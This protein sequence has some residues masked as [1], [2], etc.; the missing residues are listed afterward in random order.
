MN[1]ILVSVRMVSEK[2]RKSPL[3][4]LGKLLESMKSGERIQEG[5]PLPPALRDGEGFAWL[6]R[7]TKLDLESRKNLKEELGGLERKVE[8]L[9]Q[10]IALQQS[11]AGALGIRERVTLAHAVADALSL[12][13]GAFSRLNITVERRFHAA[14]DVLT[15]RHKVMQILVN[16]VKNARESLEQSPEG[17]RQLTVSVEPE[18]ADKVAVRVT[19]TGIGVSEGNLSQLFRFGFTTRSEGK[20]F[21]LHMSALCAYE[22]GGDLKAE[23]AGEG[24]GATFVLVLPIDGPG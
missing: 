20:G 24:H 18:G 9:A 10:I 4:R 19:D 8:D 3:E 12:H 23:S 15:E 1:S 6:E 16:L 5:S 2:G 7:L 14:P 22:I 21:G 13:S 17:N 11:H